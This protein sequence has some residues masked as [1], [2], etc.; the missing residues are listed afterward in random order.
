MQ[1]HRGRVDGKPSEQRD[2]TFTGQVW[3]DGL[4]REDGVIV[5]TVMFPP[6]ART[7]W[8]VHGAGQILIVQNGRGFVGDADGGGHAIGA[9]DV[10]WFAPGERH[11]HGAGPDTYMTHIAISLGSSDWSEPVDDEQYA[12]VAGRP[13]D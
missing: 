12:R 2:S 8:H 13:G 11:W 9:G 3:A 6:G 10:V 5:N 4:L 1:I 7:N